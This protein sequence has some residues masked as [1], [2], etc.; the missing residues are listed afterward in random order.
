MDKVDEAILH[1]DSDQCWWDIEAYPM[2]KAIAHIAGDTVKD[3]IFV[4]DDDRLRRVEV[5]KIV[6]KYLNAH[7]N[8]AKSVIEKMEKVQKWIDENK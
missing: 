8:V 4:M 1:Y 6:I 7:S 3:Q 5:A 2:V